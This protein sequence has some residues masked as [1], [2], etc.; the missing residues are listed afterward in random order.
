ME[1]SSGCSYVFFP[2]IFETDSQMLHELWKRKSTHDL[3]YAARF[4]NECGTLSHVGFNI[5]LSFTK[6]VENMVA[7]HLAMLV[8]LFTENCWL[9]G[10]YAPTNFIFN[11]S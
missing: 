10:G 4:L 8:F 9:V 11:T 6:G 3:S 7:N 1:H 2:H 5:P